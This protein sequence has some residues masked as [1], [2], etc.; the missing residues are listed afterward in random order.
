[1]GLVD[2]NTVARVERYFN[3][4]NEVVSFEVF[5]FGDKILEAIELEA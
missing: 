5:K 3:Y 2:C 1:M 4:I